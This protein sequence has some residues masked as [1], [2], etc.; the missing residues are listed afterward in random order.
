MN[1]VLRA[2]YGI[3]GRV[4]ASGASVVGRM[5]GGSKLVR[6]LTA[7]RGLLARYAAWGAT[8][9]DSTRPLLWMH[10]P[11][12]GEGLQ[13]RPVLGQIRRARP[14]MQVAYTHYSPSAEALARAL[15]EAGLADFADYLPWDTAPQ[16]RA[17]LDALDPSVLVFA[18]VDVWPVLVDAAAARDVKLAVVS[19]TL[20]A[21]SARRS[22]LAVAILRGAYSQLDAVG[23]IDVEDAVRL[24]AL[25]VRPSAL[26]ITGDTRYDQV[27]ARARQVDR[28]AGPLATLLG[29]HRATVVAG[30]TWPADERVVLEGWWTARAHVPTLRLVVAPHEPTAVHLAAI[31]RW[32]AARGCRWAGIGGAGIQPDS[33]RAAPPLPSSAAAAPSL[34]DEPDAD[35]VLVDRVGVLGELYAAADLAFVG[36]GFH[37]AGLHSVLEPAAYGSPVVFGPQHASSRDARNLLATRAAAVVRDA[38]EFA[39]LITRWVSDPVSRR[40]AGDRAQAMVESG[41]GAAGRSVVMIEELMEGQ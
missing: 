10:A 16:V 7:R 27:W 28:T 3:A 14:A 24:R 12:V 17:A 33:A 40:D 11:S 15:R 8:G 29:G 18:K 32:A 37:G 1:G 23:A 9:R 19:A 22:R 13:A 5:G 41:L 31:E 4:A 25:G 30:S 20:S 2:A 21:Q 38:Q 39:E 34:D 6:S 36:G 26:R 35:L